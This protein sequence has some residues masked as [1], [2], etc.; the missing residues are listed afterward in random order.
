MVRFLIASLR[1]GCA[2]AGLDGNEATNV[3][4]R[5]KIN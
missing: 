2:C 1:A 4:E 3:P 5:E